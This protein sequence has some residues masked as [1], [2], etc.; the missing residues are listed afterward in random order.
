MRQ[1]VTAL[2]AEIGARRNVTIDL[3]EMSLVNPAVMDRAFRA[4]MEQGCAELSI[5]YMDIPSGAGHDAA[6]FHDAGIPAA[7]IFVRNANGSHNPDEAMD[8]ADFAL[9]TRL[10]TWTLAT[11]D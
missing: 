10:L 7:M 11:A 6:D 5:P 8:M 4:R 1:T 9:A 3:G 2:A